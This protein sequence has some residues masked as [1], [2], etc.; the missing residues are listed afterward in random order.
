[1]LDQNS[2]QRQVDATLFDAYAPAE[3]ANRIEKAGITKSALPLLPL[4]ALSILAGA[5]IAFGAMFYT[6]AMTQTDLGFGPSRVFGGVV[7]CLGLVLVVVG[8]AEL[9]TG[10]SLIVM[11]WADGRI[12]TKALLRNWGVTF[13][14][15]LVGAVLMAGLVAASGTLDM[16]AGAVGETAQAIAA[17]KIVLD[18]VQ[19]L[20]RGILCNILVCLAIWL[21]FA[22]HS[23]T[24]KIMAILFPITAFVALGFEH[25]IANMYFIPV[26]MISG[27]G[28]ISMMDFV[29]NMVPVTVGNVIGGGVFVALTYYIIY[30]R[31]PLP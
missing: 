17:A 12:K 5:F 15:N 8:G 26:A 9:F 19:A 24:A 4:I 27:D 20:V 7:F 13:C 14:G 11:G 23:V 28:T 25:S 6:V 18:P 31:K 2:P 30:L 1:M 29:M 3:I 10:N 22:A 21:C 16:A